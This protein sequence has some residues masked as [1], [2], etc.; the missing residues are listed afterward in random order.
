MC[1]AILSTPAGNVHTCE[2]AAVI[3]LHWY[4]AI[5]AASL[6][7]SRSN[8]IRVRSS[9]LDASR[10][11]IGRSNAFESCLEESWRRERGSLLLDMSRSAGA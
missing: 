8:A 10:R 6:L 4:R 5:L 7:L 3:D 1:S 9:R 2:T 11:D